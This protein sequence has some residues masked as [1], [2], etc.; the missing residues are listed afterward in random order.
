MY[1]KWYFDNT[2]SKVAGVFTSGATAALIKESF[3]NQRGIVILETAPIPEDLLIVSLEEVIFPAEWL[4]DVILPDNLPVINSSQDVIVEITP[5]LNRNRGKWNLFSGRFRCLRSSAPGRTRKKKGTKTRRVRTQ[6]M[7]E[8]GTYYSD[9]S[10]PESVEDGCLQLGLS[11]DLID[12]V[13]KLRSSL[14]FDKS[15]LL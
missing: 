10:A 5:E 7:I 3:P 9:E 14:F 12:L 1:R 2:R 8:G 11:Q 13:W 4:P 6:D 15:L